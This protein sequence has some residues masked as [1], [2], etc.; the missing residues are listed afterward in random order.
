MLIPLIASCVPK[1]AEHRVDLAQ[2]DVIIIVEVLRNICGI[3]TI[4]EYQRFGKWN[5]QTLV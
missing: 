3:G 5:V 4:D 2:A 1:N